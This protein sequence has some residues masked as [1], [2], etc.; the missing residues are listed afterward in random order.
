[1]DIAGRYIRQPQNTEVDGYV[2][3]N[4]YN[5]T[6]K[7]NKKSVKTGLAQGLTNGVRSNPSSAKMPQMSLSKSLNPQLLICILPESK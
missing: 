6:T 5:R 2:D 1:M 3:L 4:A 7:K